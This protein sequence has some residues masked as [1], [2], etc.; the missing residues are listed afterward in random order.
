MYTT[1]PILLS[2]AILVLFDIIVFWGTKQVFLGQ[3]P[4]YAIY[5]C[6]F[7]YGMTPYL[8]YLAIQHKSMT[9]MHLIWNIGA[10]VTLSLIGIFYFKEI[11]TSKEII[12]VLLAVVSMILMT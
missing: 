12:G 4:Y 11:L 3:L 7:L 2:G 8:F 5:L 6:M 10:D 1:N 9:V